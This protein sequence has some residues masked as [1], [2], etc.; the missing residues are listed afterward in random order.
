[1]NQPDPPKPSPKPGT[2]KTK[3][4]SANP[5]ADPNLPTKIN[6]SAN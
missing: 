1:M 4:A 6:G 5:T 3:A 2:A